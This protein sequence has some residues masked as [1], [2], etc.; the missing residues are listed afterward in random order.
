M[1]LGCIPCKRW[2]PRGKIS[3]PTTPA[4]SVARLL[5]YSFCLISY[6]GCDLQLGNHM[7]V[8]LP[9]A[10]GRPLIRAIPKRLTALL[11]APG[12]SL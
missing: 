5:L 6:F 9:A 12:E 4:E 11:T 10:A 2:L 8:R 1:Q 3:Q 7:R